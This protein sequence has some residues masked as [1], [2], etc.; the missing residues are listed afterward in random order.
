MKQNK[1][2]NDEIYNKLMNKYKSK[3]SNDLGSE[4]TSK[5]NF[6]K[7]QNTKNEDGSPEKLNSIEYE[8]FKKEYIPTHMTLYEKACNFA[9]KVLKIKP[10]EQKEKELQESIDIAHLNIT[11]TGATSL[12]LLLP[13]F[14]MTFGALFG[15]LIENMFF[16]TPGAPPGMFF[17]VFFVFVGIILYPAINKIPSFL[18]NS[19]RLKASNQ[20]VLCVFY[21]VTYMRHTSNLENAIEFASEHLSPPLSLDMKRILWNVET[22]KYESV[23]ESLDVYLESWKKWNMEFIE[24]MH[25]IESSLYET[26]EERRVNSL[27]KAINV[28]LDETY[29]KMLHYAHGLQSPLMMLNMMGIILPILGLVILP[30]AVSFLETIKWYH[31]AMIYNVALPIGVF[32]LGTLILSSRPTGYGASDIEDNNEIKKYKNVIL[33]IGGQEVKV[34]PSYIALFVGI[35]LFIIGTSPLMMHKIN[36]DF[37][38]PL[39]GQD[40]DG[41]GGYFLMAYKPN[42]TYPDVVEGPFGFGAAILSFCITL[43]FGLSIGLYF[44]L[45]SDNIIKIR[46]ETKKLEIEFAAALFQ[47]GNRLGDGLPPEIAFSKV[48]EVMEGTVSGQFFNEVTLRITKLGMSVEQAI[49]DKQHGA[50]VLYPSSLIES[51]MKVFLESSKKGPRVASNALIN[52]SEYIKE[53]HK[54]NERLKDLLAEVI[55]SMKSQTSFLTPVISG[56]VIGITSMITSILINLGEQFKKVGTGDQTAGAMGGFTDFF[57][58]GIPTFY[59]QIIVGIYVIQIIIILTIL[60]N[61]IENGSDKL[62]E[63]YLLGKNLIKGTIL[64][65][66]LAIAISFAFNMVASSIMGS[67][68]LG[69]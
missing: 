60:T 6:S 33:N 12:G 23:K 15:Y 56:I 20:M 1:D 31:L 19:W 21:I 5:S 2:L 41:Q 9:E 52:V 11:P 42:K 13:G 25:L 3:I 50:L 40:R 68:S 18:A 14:F 29:D 65:C 28:M 44:K 7:S 63:R 17:A 36:P 49:F 57:G 46:E 10:D 22:G 32:Y 35:I 53:I 69:G 8:D 62:N 58:N 39:W 43:A 47:L 16:I 59:F 34:P 64:Y 27:D 61:G 26:A 54:V 38:V 45:R 51:S 66:M 48:A 67:L 24:A 37:E 4:D 55:S 30:L